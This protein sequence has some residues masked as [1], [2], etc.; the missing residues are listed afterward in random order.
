[1]FEQITKYF[2]IIGILIAIINTYNLWREG[3]ERVAQNPELENGWK[4]I[5]VIHLIL[6]GLPFVVMGIGIVFGDV[7]SVWDFLGETKLNPYVLA[8]HLIT[9]LMIISLFSWTLFFGGAKFLN[10]HFSNS[11]KGTWK[12]KLIYIVLLLILTLAFGKFYVREFAL[13]FG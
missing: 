7:E 4:K 3:K 10:K 6:H 11:E 2:W 5:P 1:M 9:V 8:F 13:L 12:I